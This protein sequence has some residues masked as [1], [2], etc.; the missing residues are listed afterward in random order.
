MKRPLNPAPSK[1][2]DIELPESAQVVAD[3][4]GRDATLQLT[5]VAKGR[6]IYIP[7]TLCA[8]HGI[9]RCG[10]SSKETRPR[11][12]CKG[13]WLA[14]TVG[15][16]LAVLLCRTFGGESLDLAPCYYVH[17]FERNRRIRDAFAAG[18]SQLDLRREHG[19]SE[20]AIRYIVKGWNG[21]QDR[22]SSKDEHHNTQQTSTL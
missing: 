13:H 16:E 6:K 14:A 20:R 22:P 4:I 18:K 12:T 3:V 21:R 5:K 9:T 17:A 15:D 11:C 10:R 1:P 7:V 8:G 19:M 2:E